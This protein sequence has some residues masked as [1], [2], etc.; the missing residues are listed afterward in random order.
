V[1]QNTTKAQWNNTND[2][3]GIPAAPQAKSLSTGKNFDAAG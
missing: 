3:S 1:S 2:G